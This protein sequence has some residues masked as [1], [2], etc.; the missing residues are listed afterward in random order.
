MSRR[1]FEVLKVPVTTT[2]ADG[3]ASGSANSEH[4][5][6]GKLFGVF[7]DYHGSAPA[8]T[9]VTITHT[10]AAAQTLLTLTDVNSDGWYF[11]RQQVHGNTGTGLTYDG[12][13]V[14]A[15]PYPVVGKVTVNVAQANALTAC[16]TAWLYV[17]R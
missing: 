3:S 11:P 1:R 8:T 15:E 2:G 10:H 17:E 7:L 5:V 12:T 9:D 6:N 13:R 4:P 16:V 14:V